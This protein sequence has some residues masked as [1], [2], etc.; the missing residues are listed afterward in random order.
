MRVTAKLSFAHVFIGG[1]FKFTGAYLVELIKIPRANLT[2][3]LSLGLT[4]T[5]RIQ[6]NSKKP[7]QTNKYRGNGGS[8]KMSEE[9]I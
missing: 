6:Q 8:N 7:S 3:K 4:I 1:H 2:G 5:K 9:K